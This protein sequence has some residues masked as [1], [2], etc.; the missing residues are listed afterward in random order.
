LLY[1]KQDKF[2]QNNQQKY[3]FLSKDGFPKM[4]SS[5]SVESFNQF[6]CI[7][8]KHKWFYSISLFY[9]F[10]HRRIN[11]YLAFDLESMFGRVSR[12]AE[13][14]AVALLR[15]ERSPQPPDRK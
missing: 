11:F 15:H 7:L 2:L 9:W 10:V 3:L 14:I 1:I 5:S 8:A 6:K 12:A 4:H 13:W